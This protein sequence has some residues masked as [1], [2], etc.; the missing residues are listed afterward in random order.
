MADEPENLILRE[1]RETRREHLASQESL[2]LSLRHLSTFVKSLDRLHDEF[3]KF[4]AEMRAALRD[5]RS[6]IYTS[7]VNSLNRHNDVLRVMERLS[8]IEEAIREAPQPG[9]GDMT[10]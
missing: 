6:D 10:I 8:S 2:A 5:V 9:G 7:D 3:D 1:I 4:R